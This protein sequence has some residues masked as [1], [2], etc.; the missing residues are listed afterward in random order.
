MAVDSTLTAIRTKVRRL[1]RAITESQMSNATLDEYINTFVLYDFPEELRLEALRTTYSFYTTPGIDTYALSNADLNLYTT[2][3]TPVFVAGNETLFLQ[4]R[5]EFYR[6]FPQTKALQKVGTGNGVLQ[7]FNNTIVG[8]PLLRNNVLI[9]SVDT[10][11][12]NLIVTDDGNGNLI[13]DVAAL[14]LYNV[15]DYDTGVFAVNFDVAVQD[16]T[17][18]WAQTLLYTS[19]RPSAILYYDSKFVC[20]PVPDKVYK[21]EMEAYKQPTEVA[22]GNSPDLQQWWQYIAYGA[23]KKVFEDRSDLEGVQ[24]IMPE[25]KRQENL[26]NRRTIVQQTDQRAATIYSES[27]PN[28]NNFYIKN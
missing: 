14:A 7:A 28:W 1:T 6:L 16:G 3:H 15:I 21:V 12:A 27:Y 18:I 25:F 22:A 9:T 11:G 23:A 5:T 24:M 13:G 2:F 19:T 4:D 17:D 10:A 20:R 8:T 26:V